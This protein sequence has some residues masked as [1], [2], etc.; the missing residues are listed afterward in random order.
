MT[1]T[2][3]FLTVLMV[4]SSLPN[5][6]TPVPSSERAL[7]AALTQRVV[8]AQVAQASPA[9]SN[10]PV[11]NRA[12]IPAPAAPSAY[13]PSGAA[14]VVQQPAIAPQAPPVNNPTYQNPI[15][16]APHAQQAAQPIQQ[17]VAQPATLQPIAQPQ[18]ANVA[19][20]TQRIAPPQQARQPRT[21]TKTQ[22]YTLDK[23]KAKNTPTSLKKFKNS[24]KLN[25]VQTPN[26]NPDEISAAIRMAGFAV[27]LA[28]FLF[29]AAFLLK[30]FRRTKVEAQGGPSLSVIESLW[31]GKG[32]R[33]L[34]VNVDHQQVL[35]AAT[36]TGIS[37]LAVFPNESR[38]AP[39]G[40]TQIQQT[41]QSFE[42]VIK[43]ELSQPIEA[44]AP[45]SQEHVQKL[46]RRLNTL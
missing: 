6:A 2:P 41:A 28:I 4:A 29:G 44:P 19:A 35:L 38:S 40:P 24:A 46:I 39:V 33:I 27:V 16:T 8:G 14:Q 17:P 42:S 30:K 34:L 31:I 23:V 18:R 12:E 20:P 13:Q 15:P 45:V 9:P 3:I 26:E 37:S 32:Q 11:M 10:V 25:K 7:V 21:A 36:N 5:P 43:E 22:K 1:A